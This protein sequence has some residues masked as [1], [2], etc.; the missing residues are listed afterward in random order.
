MEKFVIQ[1]EKV[2][3]IIYFAVSNWGFNVSGMEDSNEFEIKLMTHN[4][5]IERYISE[6]KETLFCHVNV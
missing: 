4:N 3:L 1:K 5:D 2:M 6:E